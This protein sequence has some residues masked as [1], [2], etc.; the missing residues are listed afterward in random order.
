MTSSADTGR[1]PGF[2]QLVV[3]SE[4]SASHS[5]RNYDGKCEAVHGHNFQV[6]VTVQGDTLSPDTQILVDFKV[7]KNG[8][9][10]VLKRFDHSHLNDVPPFTKINPS[11]ENLAREIYDSFSD[12]LNNSLQA[13]ERIHTVSVAVSEKATQTAV[14]FPRNN[15]L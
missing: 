15:A 5:L 10:H 14:F 6:E 4:F 13:A 1:T 3:R 9:K 12:Y 2:W 11:S 7:L 8:L